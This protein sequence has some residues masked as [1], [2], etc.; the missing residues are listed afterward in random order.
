MK[1]P[2][3]R[4]DVRRGRNKKSMA[5][6]RGEKNVQKRIGQ[7]HYLKRE[8]GVVP[9]NGDALRKRKS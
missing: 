8:K 7:S 5:A 1:T 6:I 3:L 2:T 4:T 9:K